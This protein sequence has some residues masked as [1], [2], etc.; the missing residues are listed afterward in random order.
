MSEP[1]ITYGYGQNFIEMADR[2][3]PENPIVIQVP[4]AAFDSIVLDYIRHHRDRFHALKMVEG[5]VFDD[6]E[7]GDPG[8]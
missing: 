6:T 2:T 1:P 8:F 5:V 3:N 4:I 7:R